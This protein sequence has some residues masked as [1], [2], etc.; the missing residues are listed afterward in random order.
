MIKD[1]KIRMKT[2]EIERIY[3]L[4]KE[5]L[6]FEEKL[7]RVDIPFMNQQLGN[8]IT[9]EELKEIINSFTLIYKSLN[10]VKKYEFTYSELN[11]ENK[12]EIENKQKLKDLEEEQKKLLQ[13]LKEERKKE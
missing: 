9:N 6:E 8:N 13:Q 1:E 7:K 4:G 3:E 11:K 2:G 12:D 10:F 5:D